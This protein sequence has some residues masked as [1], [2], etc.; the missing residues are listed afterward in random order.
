[1]K[2]LKKN[3]SESNFII[4]LPLHINQ[5]KNGDTFCIS[6][7]VSLAC[8]LLW[9]LGVISTFDDSGNLVRTLELKLSF[10]LFHVRPFLNVRKGK[11]KLTF[12]S[13]KLLLVIIVWQSER[14][15]NI[16]QGR[17]QNLYAV[18]NL[19]ELLHVFF[20]KV[21]FETSSP[22]VKQKSGV[23]F[24]KCNFNNENLI[25]INDTMTIRNRKLIAT[26]SSNFVSTS[27]NSSRESVHASSYN[28][29]NFSASLVGRLSSLRSAIS[30]LLDV[31]LDPAI[32]LNL[33][34]KVKY[35][36]KFVWNRFE[37]FLLLV[38]HTDYLFI[39]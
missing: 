3:I 2:F 18:C 19:K 4:K 7:T 30:G 36:F 38:D 35:I 5:I 27:V 22:V 11:I 34:Y 28:W 29:L 8:R 32:L 26:V 23:T 24:S 37:R 15:R 25:D 6:E 10:S 16:E 12:V 39:I 1:M 21:K 31:N 14:S 33:W 9:V 20:I 13:F 17:R